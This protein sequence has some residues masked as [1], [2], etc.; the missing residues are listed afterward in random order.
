MGDQGSHQ[1][2][3]DLHNMAYP[4]VQGNLLAY[5]QN[6]INRHNN[7][8]KNKPIVFSVLK[9][10]EDENIDNEIMKKWPS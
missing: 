9:F 5:E 3:G 4:K 6:H 1:R 10:G 8:E 7:K 2:G